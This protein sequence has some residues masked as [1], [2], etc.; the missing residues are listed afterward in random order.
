MKTSAGYS[1]VEVLVAF[2]IMATVLAV[3]LPGSA[4]LYA[5]LPDQN[6]RLL[7]Y[8]YALSRLSRLGVE[9]PLRIGEE[10]GTYRDIWQW[11]E[12]IETDES[13]TAD[14]PIYEVRVKVS[15]IGDEEL[16]RAAALKVAP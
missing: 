12:T 16:A 6:E 2:A 15:R 7:A 10:S 3:L 4:K 13:S 14:L 9:T 1:L 5:R 11:T 8:D